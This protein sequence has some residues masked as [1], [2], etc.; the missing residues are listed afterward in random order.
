[1]GNGVKKAV[2]KKG[3]SKRKHRVW[4]MD[5]VRSAKG[6]SV[7][8]GLQPRSDIITKGDVANRDLPESGA[9]TVDDATTVT[10]VWGGTYE[11]LALAQPSKGDVY[12]DYPKMPVQGSTLLPRRGGL[13]QLTILLSNR[14]EESGVEA[15]ELY[16]RWEIDWQQIEKDLVRHPYIADDASAADIIEDVELW[17]AGESKLRAQ[18]KYVDKDGSELTL[19]DKALEVATKLQRGQ[20]SYVVYA[21]V[22]R[23][24]TNYQGR[25][26]A[27]TCGY[28]DVPT[29][30]IAGFVYLKTGDRLAQ[31]SDDMW[32]RTEE[33][34]GADSWDADIYTTASGWNAAS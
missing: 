26:D 9:W 18:F 24:L 12:L 10:L 1:M 21:P 17:K 4:S 11:A 34:T 25:P 2:A 31:Q 14:M 13:G 8:R 19:L 5:E 29:E 16:S 23:L 20:E 6:V 27:A 28:I 30:S 33:W 32:T 7:A 3:I 22:M 15:D